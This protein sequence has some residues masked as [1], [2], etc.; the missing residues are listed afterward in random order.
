[1]RQAP[2]CH[3]PSRRRSPV[4]QWGTASHAL[5]EPW[6]TYD[7]ALTAPSLFTALL[8]RDPRRAS[9][10]PLREEEASRWEA[11]TAKTRPGRQQRDTAAPMNHQPRQRQARGSRRLLLRGCGRPER[12]PA[13]GCLGGQ[14]AARS[15]RSG[16]RAGRS[17]PRDSAG[18]VRWL[19]V[20]PARSCLCAPF[21]PRT[22]RRCCWASFAT[23]QW[24][25]GNTVSIARASAGWLADVEHKSGL[26]VAK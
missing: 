15:C 21:A 10:F 22:A 11:A 1:M 26:L 19:W 2:R 6:G 17:A 25:S 3:V 13:R 5:Q 7:V 16:L 18:S 24:G 9:R 12:W 23:T 8:R 20:P 14:A 4:K